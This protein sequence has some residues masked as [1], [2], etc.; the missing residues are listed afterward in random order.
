[1]A[2][3][4]SNVFR[5]FASCLE[6]HGIVGVARHVP[7]EARDDPLVAKTIPCRRPLCQHADEG[8]DR[9]AVGVHTAA[10]VTDCAERDSGARLKEAAQPVGRRRHRPTYRIG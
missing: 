1:M 6:R 5:S 9:I 4:I 3:R 7:S 8:H 10:D 2:F